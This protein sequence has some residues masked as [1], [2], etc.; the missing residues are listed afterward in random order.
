MKDFREYL[1]LKSK[2]YYST[3]GHLQ[4]SNKLSPMVPSSLLKSKRSNFLEEKGP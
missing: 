1:Y 4:K 2:Q 3:G